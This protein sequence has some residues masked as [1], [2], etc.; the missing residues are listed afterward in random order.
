MAITIGYQSI[1]S[2]THIHLGWHPETEHT[3]FDHYK[4]QDP[5]GLCLWIKTD[6]NYKLSP[7]IAS[8]EIPSASTPVKFIAQ[9]LSPSQQDPR[10]YSSQAPPSFA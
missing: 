4:L 2:S 3:H 5:C 1:V 8:F 10:P 7:L 6:G 9:N